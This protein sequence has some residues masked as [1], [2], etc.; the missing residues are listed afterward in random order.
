M[1]EKIDS[2]EMKIQVREGGQYLL[3]ETGAR[4]AASTTP[5]EPPSA[6]SDHEE[7]DH[8]HP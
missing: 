1:D 6:E 3:D 4:I 7:V 8:A 2:G 5:K